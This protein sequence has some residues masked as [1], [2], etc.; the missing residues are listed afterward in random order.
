MAKSSPIFPADPR[1]SEILYFLYHEAE[2]LDELRFSEWLELLEEDINYRMPLPLNRTRTLDYSEQTEIIAENIHSLR[3]RISKL[4]TDYAWADTPPSRTR[5]MV[6][7]LRVNTTDRPDE[8][9]AVSSFLVYRNRLSDPNPDLF[10]G[11]RKDLL[12]KVNGNWRLAK[13]TIFLDQTVVGAR[14]LTILF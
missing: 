2:L 10:A 1:Y 13:R 4:K 3:V 5:H 12:R 7:N 9:E 14:H 11:E 6:T 8:A